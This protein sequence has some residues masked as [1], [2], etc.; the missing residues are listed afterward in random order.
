MILLFLFKKLNSAGSSSL[1]LKQQSLTRRTVG[2]ICE[3]CSKS[4]ADETSQQLLCPEYQNREISLIGI[5]LAER[6]VE[7]LYQRDCNL[8]RLKSHQLK[9]LLT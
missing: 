2:S 4:S 8:K 9:A 5:V 7:T 6:L 3:E 1:E